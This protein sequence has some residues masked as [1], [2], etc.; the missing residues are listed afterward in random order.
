MLSLFLKLVPI[1]FIAL[2]AVLL[3]ALGAFA[4]I[5]RKKS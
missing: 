4:A 5:R 1:L 3:I 2:A